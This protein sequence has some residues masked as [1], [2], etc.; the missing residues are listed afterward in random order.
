MFLGRTFGFSPDV[1]SKDCKNTGNTGRGNT[2]HG[3]ENRKS[4]QY[5]KD[6]S[7][8]NGYSVS[9]REFHID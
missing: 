7:S 2:F 8:G 1:S 6:D 5:S 9:L 4:S 3:F